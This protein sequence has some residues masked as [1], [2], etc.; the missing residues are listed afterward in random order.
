[1]SITP[2]G[3]QTV[4]SLPSSSQS[5]NWQNVLNAA[6]SALGLSPSDL[7]TQLASGSSLSSIA[8]SQGVSQDT[9]I[10]SITSALKQNGQLSGASASQLQQ[11][12][13]SIANRT[14]SAQGHHH[15]HSHGAGGASESSTLLAALDG[16]SSTDGSSSSSTDSSSSD[17]SSTS[18]GFDLLA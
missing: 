5:S 4:W 16:D 18:Q 6:S 17:G 15:H 2:I 12:A 14:P 11:V 13:T 7:Q 8:Q 3:S 9:L 10:Q 1:M